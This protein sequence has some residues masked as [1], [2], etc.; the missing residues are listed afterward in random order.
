MKSHTSKI[1]IVYCMK[2]ILIEWD[3]D[4]SLFNFNDNHTAAHDCKPNSV[5]IMRGLHLDILLK[6]IFLELW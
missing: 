3:T 6:L 1:A 2:S 5:N 4:F